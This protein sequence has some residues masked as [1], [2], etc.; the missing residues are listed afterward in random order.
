MNLSHSTAQKFSVSISA[1]YVLAVAIVMWLV[2]EHTP[3][4][5]CM[6]AVGGNPTAAR[7]NGINIKKYTIVPF[8]VSSVITA[9]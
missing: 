1:F 9:F 6:Y 7:L 8:I 3:T 2:T 5:R 4:G